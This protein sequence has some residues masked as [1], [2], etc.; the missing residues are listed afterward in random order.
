MVDKLA[1]TQLNL[2]RLYALQ[3][4]FVEATKHTKSAEL[5]IQK[6]S[7]S[8]MVQY[9]LEPPRSDHLA[10]LLLVS[11]MPTARSTCSKRNGIQRE[12]ALQNVSTLD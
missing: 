6:S 7:L 5:V 11:I 1:V 2:G 4:N 9:D 8:F 3:G 10:Y 12:R